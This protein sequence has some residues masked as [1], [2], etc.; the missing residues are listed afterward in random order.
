MTGP[1]VALSVA[2]PL[3]RTSQS[4]DCWDQIAKFG[5][6]LKDDGEG[7]KEALFNLEHLGEFLQNFDQQRNPLWADFNHDFGVALARY[8]ALAL[9]VNGVVL[10]HVAKGA[11]GLP[12]ADELSGHGDGEA[13]IEDGLYAHRF[14]VTQAGEACLPNVYYVSPFFLTDGRD[15]QGRQIGYTLLNIAWVNGPFLDGMA[16]LRMHVLHSDSVRS[17]MADEKMKRYGLGDNATAEQMQAAMSKYADE[18]DDEKKKSDEA[19]SRYR[20]F[21]EALG[22]EE[23]MG[24]FID[25]ADTVKRFKR[26]A[27]GGSDPDDKDDKADK[28]KEYSKTADE[29]EMSV[30]ASELGVPAKMSAI[31]SKVTELRFTS[32]P[33]T[34]LAALKEQLG[35]LALKQTKRDED[36]REAGILSFAKTAISDRAWDPDDETGLVEFY[37]ASPDKASEAIERNKKQK[38]WDKVIAMQRLTSGGAPVGKLPGPTLNLA[39]GGDGGSDVSKR[40]DAEVHKIAGEDKVTYPV[41]MTR[42]KARNPELYAAYVASR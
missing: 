40:F 34:E 17:K 13:V 4:A 28:E 21:A 37:R 1:R 32:A 24:R 38:T 27:E 19:M 36:D 31:R 35:E 6:F 15:E 41:A 7:P 14:E 39:G 9:V 16:P 8:D 5:R 11:V 25:D 2:V 23:A 18:I 33:K 22:G 42:V 26:F 12:G 20:R 30:L 10:Q 29:R 3:R